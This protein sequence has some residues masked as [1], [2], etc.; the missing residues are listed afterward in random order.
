[1]HAKTAK[2]LLLREIRRLQRKNENLEGQH[3][4][5]AEKH[6]WVEQV[7][8]TFKNDTQCTE[9]IN[10]LKHGDS[11][12]SIA[13]WLGRPITKYSAPSLPSSEEDLAV[14]IE[15]YHQELVDNGDSRYW[16]STTDDPA[17]I[18][19]LVTLYLTWV[20]PFHM[21]F[22]E[23]QFMISFRSCSDNYCSAALVNAVC[24]MSCHLLGSAPDSDGQTMGAI[25]GLKTRFFDEARTLLRH[26][27]IE[28]MTSIQTLSVLFLFEL[29][30]GTGQM[31]GAHLRLASEALVA[32]QENEQ[33]EE[34]N[35]IAFWGVL[36]VY[37]YVSDMAQS[38]RNC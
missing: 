8:E 28:K 4:A 38:C 13:Q 6:A 30:S 2:D 27:H 31:A 23:N 3:N 5:L 19:H 12:Q 35:S 17:L 11:P 26:T 18:E 34:A 36:T 32:K 29:G 1:M 7:I 37:T 10:R 24:A 9:V 15:K 21:L 16:T 22:D 33:S 14:A 25:K 20:H